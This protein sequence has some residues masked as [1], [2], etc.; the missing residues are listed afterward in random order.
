MTAPTPPEAFPDRRIAA[1]VRLIWG[2]AAL[3][4]RETHPARTGSPGP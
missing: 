4:L 3:T 1:T 2:L